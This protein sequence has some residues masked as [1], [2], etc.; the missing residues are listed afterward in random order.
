MHGLIA[1]FGRA[2][3]DLTRETLVASLEGLAADQVHLLAGDDAM[4]VAVL[5]P[6]IPG[7]APAVLWGPGG[8]RGLAVGGYLLLDDR[9]PAAGHPERLLHLIAQQKELAAL[10]SEVAQLKASSKP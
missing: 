10:R 3:R 2:A 5:T 9:A 6:P 4:R 8:T 7:A 1:A